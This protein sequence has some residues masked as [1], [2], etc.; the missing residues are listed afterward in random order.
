MGVRLAEFLFFY[1]GGRTLLYLA[2]FLIMRVRLRN[3][4]PSIFPNPS[5]NQL[6]H[7]TSKLVILQERMKGKHFLCYLVLSLRIL[8][9]G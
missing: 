2:G 5:T 4:F 1:V 8:K 9:N 6:D 3:L 7:G